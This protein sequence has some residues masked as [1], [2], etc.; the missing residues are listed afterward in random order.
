MRRCEHYDYCHAV[1]M[2]GEYARKHTVSIPLLQMDQ[3]AQFV[4]REAV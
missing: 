2:D 1:V 4:A 3:L